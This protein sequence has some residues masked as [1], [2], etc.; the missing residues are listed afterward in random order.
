MRPYGEGFDR[1]KIYAEDDNM[2]IADGDN[3]K[4]GHTIVKKGD[5]HDGV[6]NHYLPGTV[7]PSVVE[8][9]MFEAAN[10]RVG[11]V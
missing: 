3:F 8:P 5:G 2:K 7:P 10:R 4:S 11:G 9:V 6:L 1:H